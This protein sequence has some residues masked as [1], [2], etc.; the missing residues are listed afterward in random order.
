MQAALGKEYY[1]PNPSSLKNLSK[2][3][4]SIASM[5][6]AESDEHSESEAGESVLAQRY[7]MP[8]NAA[9]VSSQAG[10]RSI[11]LDVD[12]TPSLPKTLVSP[13]PMP[14]K[15]HH[16]DFVDLHNP[17]NEDDI[18]LWVESRIQHK[19]VEFTY[20]TR[21]E[22]ALAQ[23]KKDKSRMT[24]ILAGRALR[25]KGLFIPPANEQHRIVLVCTAAE[26]QAL[27]QKPIQFEFVDILVI[28]SMNL[29]GAYNY[30]SEVLGKPSVRRAAILSLADYFNLDVLYILDDNIASLSFMGEG[31]PN[32]WSGVCD[33]LDGQAT[34]Y[35]LLIA[36]VHL[37]G[38]G[39]QKP[40]VHLGPKIYRVDFE[41]LNQMLMQRDIGIHCLSVSA[42]DA[43]VPCEDYYL[44]LAVNA[45]LLQGD[46]QGFIGYS[47]L[48]EEII[49]GRRSQLSPKQAALH[50][51]K[52]RALEP[53]QAY[54]LSEAELKVVK[55]TCRAFSNLVREN[56]A[57]R[58]QTRAEISSHSTVGHV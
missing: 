45:A 8:Q 5:P 52:I 13:I 36:T 54:Y 56:M 25:K 57:A 10:I 1:L 27:R 42:Q 46:A 47:Q 29:G 48:P 7:Q 4:V 38:T 51:Q 24:F 20:W 14:N 12:S 3:K 2:R 9:A 28:D 40:G 23:A 32:N 21:A 49:N 31:R 35:K 58:G 16:I 39:P 53:P 18:E 19:K 43:S 41:H 33:V 44:Q 37:E 17:L 26:A 15:T 11:Y 50:L 30:P 6:E 34:K 55:A 22:Y